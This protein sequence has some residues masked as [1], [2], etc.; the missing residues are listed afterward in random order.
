MILPIHQGYDTHSTQNCHPALK[1]PSITFEHVK[2]SFKTL[3]FLPKIF[4]L[5]FI[6]IIKSLDTIP[7]DDPMDQNY[8]VREA[9]QLL[10]MQ[11]WK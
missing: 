3:K 7:R 2:C 1:S 11:V 6:L 10:G 5:S 9:K 8:L 4:D